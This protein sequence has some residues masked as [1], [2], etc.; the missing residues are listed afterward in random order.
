MTPL[1]LMLFFCAENA[2][3]QRY[4]PVG[5]WVL[6]EHSA[7]EESDSI[8][9]LERYVEVYLHFDENGTYRQVIGDSIAFTGSWKLNKSGKLLKVRLSDGAKFRVSGSDRINFN[10]PI[11]LI[12]NFDFSNNNEVDST[13]GG[14]SWYIRYPEKL[15]EIIQLKG[16][17]YIDSIQTQKKTSLINK[18]WSV[19]IT[20]L[21]PT[22]LFVKTSWKYNGPIKDDRYVDFPEHKYFVKQY[23]ID[24]IGDKQLVLFTTIDKKNVFIYLKR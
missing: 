14:V 12:E 21:N 1:F 23:Y 8:T 24:E 7:T 5:K 22:Y 13:S 18:D 17:W 2:T 10:T 6:K 19:E 9:W 15:S 20:E 16:V 3:A 11:S 4:S